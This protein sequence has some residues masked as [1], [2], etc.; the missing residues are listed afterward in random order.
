V[1]TSTTEWFPFD[2]VRKWLASGGRAALLQDFE[3]TLAKPGSVAWGHQGQLRLTQHPLWLAEPGAQ[4]LPQLGKAVSESVFSTACGLLRLQRLDLSLESLRALDWL[5]NVLIDAPN[6]Q[7]GQ[8]PWHVRNAV[9]LGAYAGEVFRQHAPAQWIET[10]N[11]GPDRIS[12]QLHNGLLICPAQ[13]LL[14]CAIGQRPSN[15][16]GLILNLL[17][18]PQG[19]RA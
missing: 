19:S 8:E 4:D 5:A 18:H 6:A 2:S 15:F 10:S 3:G 1:R 13:N 17:S 12:L 7:S 14:A 16:E 9:L 11:Q